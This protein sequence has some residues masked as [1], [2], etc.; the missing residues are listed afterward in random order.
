MTVFS[1]I[2][3]GNLWNGT[4]TRSG[5]G[6]NRA[7]TTRVSEALLALVAELGISSVVD[8]ACGEGYWQPE[9]P[10]YV[11]LDVAPEAIEAA[12]QFHPD[13]EYRVHDARSGCP[14]ADLVICRDALQHLSLRDG[15]RMLAAIRESGSTWLLASTYVGG[16]NGSGPSGRYVYFE[17]DLEAAPYSLPPALRLLRD[18]FDYQ[19]PDVI[20]DPRKMLG[21]WRLA[22]WTDR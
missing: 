17:P 20:R 8:V 18:G 5:P 4:E 21:L 14:Q 12:R 2:Y 7:P 13:R 16:T 3:Q 22:D 6:S 1:R 9:L 11:G 19:H 10:G 15:S